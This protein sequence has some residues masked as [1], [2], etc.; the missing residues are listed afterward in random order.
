ME[1]TEE[2]G[3][4]SGKPAVCGAEPS[5]IPRPPSKHS[6]DTLL[7]VVPRQAR[8]SYLHY[9]LVNVLGVSVHQVDLLAVDVL[10]N[11]GLQVCVFFGHHRGAGGPQEE[12]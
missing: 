5:P 8:R 1:K 11:L 6:A 2:Q 3:L 12:V 4:L 10:D 7:A 9:V